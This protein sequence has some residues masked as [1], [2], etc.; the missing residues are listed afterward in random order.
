MAQFSDEIFHKVI[1]DLSIGI[2]IINESLE[3]FEWNKWMQIYS[4]LEKEKLIGQKFHHL[5]KNESAQPLIRKIKKCL[6]KGVE[7]KVSEKF[8]SNPLPLFL[9]GSD[10]LIPQG[11]V[12]KPLILNGERHCIVMITDLTLYHHKQ[13]EIIRR[14][15]QLI[16]NKEKR[17]EMK[18]MA[19][20]GQMAA[21]I[22]HEIN[23]PLTVVD[24]FS[25]RIEKM[26]E[27]G[28]IDKQLLEKSIK[29]ISTMTH[30]MISI[31]EGL[32]ILSYKDKSNVKMTE[33]E[34]FSVLIEKALYIC[35]QNIKNNSV[36]II[37]D[38][39]LHHDDIFCIPS[40]IIQI[41]T[42]LV[43]NSVYEIKNKDN[44]WIKISITASKDKYQARIIDSGNGI[45]KDVIQKIFDP[46]YTS[47]SAGDGTG[48]GLSLS[49][50]LAELHGG[51][52]YVDEENPNTCF[53]LEIPVLK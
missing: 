38:E 49:S 53:V 17:A 28:D 3:I 47:K 36:K 7:I 16:K 10:E 26:V 31:V 44:P 21:G 45:P 8:Y 50:K 42:N 37:F 12:L 34:S 18:R 1:D 5:F 11:I 35:D 15:Q 51:K 46:F 19:S 4:N 24:V 20:L 9:S 33:V 2:I 40:Q 6:E 41:I 27:S 23:N 39:K 13:E 32:K 48:L 30:H 14:D 22:V 25:R 43:N 29:N 52:L